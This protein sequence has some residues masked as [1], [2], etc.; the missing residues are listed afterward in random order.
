MR[1]RQYSILN[2]PS[3]A[4][5]LGGPGLDFIRQGIWIPHSIKPKSVAAQGE[6]V[7]RIRTTGKS[8]AHENSEE[9]EIVSIRT[10]MRQKRART[11]TFEGEI[12]NLNAQA[13]YSSLESNSAW[14]G[15]QQGYKGPQRDPKAFCYCSAILRAELKVASLPKTT[16]RAPA[17]KARF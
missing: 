3:P 7:L 14:L 12:D 5:S 10:E 6:A 2:G 1:S 13:L 17:G 11:V 16:V 9:R 15:A 4:A 8:G